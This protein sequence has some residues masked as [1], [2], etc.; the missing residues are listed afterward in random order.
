MDGDRRT[1]PQ[2]HVDAGTDQAFH[3]FTTK[4]YVLISVATRN[5]LLPRPFVEN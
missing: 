4:Y 2:L 5:P 1:R 3:A